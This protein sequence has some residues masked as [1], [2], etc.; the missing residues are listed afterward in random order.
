MGIAV[1]AVGKGLRYPPGVKVNTW[2]VGHF[3]FTAV[4]VAAC[5]GRSELMFDDGNVLLPGTPQTEVTPLEPL[6]GGDQPDRGGQ[7]PRPPTGSGVSL[8]PTPPSPDIPVPA[9]PTLIPAPEPGIIPASPLDPGPTPP[10]T[11]AIAVACEP[12]QDS[13]EFGTLPEPDDV[14]LEIGLAPRCGNGIVQS[15]EQCDDG[16]RDAGD[17]CADDCLI[18][19]RFVCFTTERGGSLCVYAGVC[20]DGQLEFGEAC[21][22]G[23]RTGGDGCSASCQVEAH[24]ACPYPGSACVQGPSCGDGLVMGLEQCD[25]DAGCR[26]CQVEPGW[27]CPDGTSCW[28]RCGDGQVVGDEACDDFNRQS[29]DGC[30]DTCRIEWNVCQEQPSLCPVN[31]GLC[32]DG[33]IDGWETCDDAN[34]EAGDGCSATCE[35]EPSCAPECAATCGNGRVEDDE[36][37]DDGNV[38]EGDGCSSACLIEFGFTC[39]HVPANPPSP[40]EPADAPIG[41][42]AGPVMDPVLTADAGT[43]LGEGVYSV[44]TTRCGDGY[45]TPLEECDS[46]GDNGRESSSCTLDCKLGN[47]CGDG[48]VSG[49]EQCDDGLNITP[50]AVRGEAGCAPGCVLPAFCGDGIVQ[51]AEEC[52]LGPGNLGSYGGCTPDCKLAP[53]C[54]DGVVDACGNEFCDDGN[55]DDND[56]CTA[57]CRP[58]Q[59]VR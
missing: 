21:D 52:D 4:I 47:Y 33:S 51:V 23:N 28:T 32:G 29:G 16:N 25:A 18:E 44:C 49:V 14:F 34:T 46:G 50:Y 1:I 5:G 54:G 6:P 55:L 19:P 37:C 57:R 48:M 12:S 36:G 10:F 27:V 3:V 58:R 35:T 8:T 13:L 40:A 15:E 53:R 31:V 30:S 39:V 11:E 22:D 9:A 17:G 42:D 38:I 2:R 41:P 26:N 24:Y 43:E 45:Q 56:G 59:R 20:G 7:P